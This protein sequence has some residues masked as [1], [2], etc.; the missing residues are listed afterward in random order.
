MDLSRFHIIS[1][2]NEFGNSVWGMVMRWGFFEK[3]TIGKQIVRSADSI[4]A[5]MSEAYGRYHYADRKRFCYYARGSLCE[6]KNWMEI[7]IERKLV[8]KEEGLEMI[9]TMEKISRQINNYIRHLN[10]KST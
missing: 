6:T 3:D 9:E 5:N 7:C 1:L 8:D 4:S 2:A 10:S